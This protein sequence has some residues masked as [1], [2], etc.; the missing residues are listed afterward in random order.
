MANLTGLQVRRCNKRLA[1]FGVATVEHSQYERLDTLHIAFC[2][3]LGWWLS[4]EV[5]VDALI[6]TEIMARN[7]ADFV[8]EMIIIYRSKV[9]C[10]SDCS[11]RTHHD[12]LRPTEAGAIRVRQQ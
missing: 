6:R 2:R 8:V 3:Y 11:V 5:N 12:R 4:F 7:H 9:I 10:S 1:D